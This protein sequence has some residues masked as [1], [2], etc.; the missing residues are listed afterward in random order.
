MGLYI[1][2][3]KEIMKISGKRLLRTVIKGWDFDDFRPSNWGNKQTY[4]S[5]KWSKKLRA[6]LKKDL[7]NEE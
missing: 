1:Q 5:K 3:I 2:W 7:R 4:A 6:A